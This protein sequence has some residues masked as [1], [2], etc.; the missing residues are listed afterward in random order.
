MVFYDQGIGT[1]PLQ[2]NDVHRLRETSDR[3]ERCALNVLDPPIRCGRFRSAGCAESLGLVVGVGLTSNV[4]QL[5]KALADSYEDGRRS[6]IYL[7]GFSRGAF[8]VR[9]LAGLIHRCGL[10]RPNHEHFSR[11]VR[12]GVPPLQTPP[13][14]EAPND[15]RAFQARRARPHTVRALPRA[16]GTPSSR[17]AASGRRAFL[18]F[19]TTRSSSN[20]RHA[21]ALDEQRSWFLPTSW[22]GIDSDPPGLERRLDCAAADTSKR[23]GSVDL[24]R[25]SAAASRTMPRHRRRC[26]GC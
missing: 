5:Y 11:R 6:V 8:T 2:V 18:I 9:V 3:E 24:T 20:V 23:S 17:T 15:G 7:I 26:A 22:G 13:T 25:M 1:D 4:K 21:L 16:S 19:V 10:L 12:R 14:D